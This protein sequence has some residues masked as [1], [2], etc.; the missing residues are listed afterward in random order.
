M[1]APPPIAV[2]PIVSPL[3]TPVRPPVLSRYPQRILCA[4]G[5]SRVACEFCRKKSRKECPGCDSDFSRIGR[6]VVCK[7]KICRTQIKGCIQC[8][9]EEER[10]GIKNIITCDECE[11]GCKCEDHQ[12]ILTV[13]ADG[14]YRCT[15]K[16]KCKPAYDQDHTCS[17]CYNVEPSVKK[18]DIC[19]SL[20][21]DGCGNVVHIDLSPLTLYPGETCRALAI[22][23]RMCSRCRDGRT[24]KEIQED[25]RD[26]GFGSEH[27]MIPHDDDGDNEEK[28]KLY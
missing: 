14:K 11:Y 1:A 9:E 26:Q 22:Y 4:C 20:F 10:E 6:Y 5:N 7:S 13:C 24:I 2:I 23:K 3:R 19:Y 28:E 16:W 12:T 27:I 21:C 15:W 17:A 8:V 25:Y 18:C